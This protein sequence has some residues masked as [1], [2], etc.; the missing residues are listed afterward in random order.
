LNPCSYQVK[1][2]CQAFTPMLS[3]RNLHRYTEAN[4]ES[5]KVKKEAEALLT[6]AKEEAATVKEEAEAEAEELKR[7]AREG[8]EALEKEKDAMEGAHTFRNSKILLDVGGHKFTTSRQTLT[9]IP[10]TYLASM[11]SGRFALATD[12]SDGA[13][14]IDREGKNFGHVLNF[15][16]DPMNCIV[17]ANNTTEAQRKERKAELELYGL[18]D[19]AMPYYAQEL[20]GQSL[21]KSACRVGTKRALQTAVAQARALVFV[22]GSTT[23]FLTEEYQDVTYAITDRVVHDS[24][25]WAADDDDTFMFRSKDGCMSIGSESDISEEDGDKAVIYNGCGTWYNADVVAPTELPSDKWLSV[26]YATLWSKL[27][28]AKPSP[29]HAMHAPPPDEDVAWVCVPEMRITVVLGGWR[30]KLNEL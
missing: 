1:A 29:M 18:L 15:L 21:L 28:S 22:M 10:N 19:R 7:E 24:P 16:R 27:A 20:V 14:F 6:N 23:P 26:A 3:K 4:E 25:V 13:Y 12:A 30:Y 8:R 11:F 5:A 2:L 9:T 17:S